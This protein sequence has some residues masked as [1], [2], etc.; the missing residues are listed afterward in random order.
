VTVAGLNPV[1]W[2]IVASPALAEK[3]GVTP[4]AGFGNDFAGVVD[5]VGVDVA[6]WQ[7]GD[8]VFGG[9]RGAALADHIIVSVEDRH[10]HRTPDDVDDLTA[11]VIDIVGRTASAVAD[12]LALGRED[13]VLI[14][15]AGGGVGSILTQLAARTGAR[16]LGTGSTD[17]AGHIRLL[18]AEPITYGAGLAERVL[19]T[20][21]AG[22]TAA[23]DLFGTDTALAALELGAPPERVVT[24]ESED[25]PPG[26]RAVNG[27]DA[28]PGAALSLLNLV[29][30]GH[31]RVPIEATYPLQDFMAA[32][33]HQRGR[34]TRGK[35]AVTMA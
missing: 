15:A 21:P 13:T 10:I 18:G 6:G 20:A 12:V 3:F 26:V 16:V 22:V 23:A 31:L 19:A 11:G 4:P 8:R 24:I 14:G 2:Q 1:D 35:I 30:D 17:S 34:H 9:A 27:S 5:A 25:P 7:V 32:I 28:R 33:R 29:K